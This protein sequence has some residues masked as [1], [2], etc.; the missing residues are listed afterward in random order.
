MSFT[1]TGAHRAAI[2][3]VYMDELTASEVFKHLSRQDIKQIAMAAREIHNANAE[4]CDSVLTDYLTQ[5]DPGSPALWQGFD[6]VTKLAERSLGPKAAKALFDED[7]GELRDVLD[8][9]EPRLLAGLLEKEHPQ[10]I[11]LVLAH[12]E[13]GKCSLVLEQIPA[14]LQPDILRRLANLDTVTPEMT[15]LLEDALIDEIKF[16]ESAGLSRQLGGIKLVADIMNNFEKSREENLMR[17]LE[18]LDEELA[19]E[20]RGLMFIF[21]DLI[22]V[23]D[24]GVQS[25]LKEVDRET[26]MLALKAA[27]E[28]VRQHIF[29]N[30]STRAVEMILDDMEARG[31]VRLR[32]VERAQASIVRVALRLSQAGVIILTKGSDDAYV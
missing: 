27:D 29:K 32:D 19:E 5:L 28:Q 13:T 20:V 15:Q 9:A 4:A 30:L 14:D 17:Q 31:P 11:A 24:R 25:L 8:R 10:T 16:S 2:L 21:D 18:F 23:D 1:L 22:Y 12:M 26:L 3:I 6:Y 7:S